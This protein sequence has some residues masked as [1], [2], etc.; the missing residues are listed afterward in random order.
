MVRLRRNLQFC[1]L[2]ID[3]QK[4]TNKSF[5]LDA[6][7][8]YA[9]E[10]DTEP[11]TGKGW[12]IALS[13]QNRVFKDCGLDLQATTQLLKAHIEGSAVSFSRYDVGPEN[14]EI[15]GYLYMAECWRCLECTIRK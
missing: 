13:L 10:L 5:F 7:V 14:S 1:P 15:F 4:Y 9:L 6:L 8:L 3:V 11:M 12:N 2:L